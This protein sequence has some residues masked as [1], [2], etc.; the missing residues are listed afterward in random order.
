MASPTIES[1]KSTAPPPDSASPRFSRSR[2]IPSDPEEL[3]LLIADLQDDASRSRMREAVWVSIILHFIILVGIKQL[4]KWLP[5]K[6]VVLLTPEQVVQ[7]DDKQLTYLEQPPDTQK[8][9]ETPQTSKIS[10]KDRIATSKNPKIDPRVLERLANNRR[11]GSPGMNPQQPFAPPQPQPQVQQ[12]QG[13]SPQQLAQNTPPVQ[14]NTNPNAALTQPQPQPKPNRNIFA[15]AG[16]P[17]NTVNEAVRNAARTH[18]GISGELGGGIGTA[19]NAKMG[20]VE[21]LSDTMGVD[22]GP[23]MQ[24]VIQAIRVNW[25]AIIPE[26]A[27]EPMLKQGNVYIQFVIGKDGKVSGMRLEGPSG[28]VSLDRAAWGGI[29]G[30][31]PFPPLPNQ[32]SGPYLALRIKFMYNPD[33]TEI[34]EMRALHRQ[35]LGLILIAVLILLVTAARYWKVH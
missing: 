23:Y 1:P 24:R 30:S 35:A 26:S 8:P 3:H 21:I 17:A 27:R 4:P 14:Q 16:T 19:R 33:R 12:Q 20:D 2:Y 32:F 11:E 31:N 29:T 22:F 6:S 34:R 7:K 9:T 10:D 13:G 5:E 18:G 15:N 28:D 25:Y